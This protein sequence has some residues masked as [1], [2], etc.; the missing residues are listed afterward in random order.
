MNTALDLEDI[1]GLILSGYGDKPAARYAMFEIV[2]GADARK[3]LRPLI[4]KLQ[5]GTF[6]RTRRREPPF[7]G[8][9]C[10]N[11]AFTHAG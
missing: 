4:Q 3:W 6:S 9:L 10:F 8:D 1:Q 5:F 7:L 11:I 2:N